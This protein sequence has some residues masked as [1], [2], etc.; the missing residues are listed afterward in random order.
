MAAAID[1]SGRPLANHNVVDRLEMMNRLAPVAVVDVDDAFVLGG[2]RSWAAS[3]SIRPGNTTGQQSWI[4][5]HAEGARLIRCGFPSG[6][7]R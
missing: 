5:E 7:G 4:S 2:G 3:A 1:P 6:P